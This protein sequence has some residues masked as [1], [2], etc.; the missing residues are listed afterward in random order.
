MHY[1]NKISA[2]VILFTFSKSTN[3][4][5]FNFLNEIYNCESDFQKFQGFLKNEN[6]I[7]STLNRIELYQSLQT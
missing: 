6:L 3:I 2:I 5:T 7:I 1:R 4:N